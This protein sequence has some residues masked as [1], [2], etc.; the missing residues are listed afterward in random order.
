M[1]GSHGGEE[2]KLYTDPLYVGAGL[3][4]KGPCQSTLMADASPPSRA[5][6]LPHLV[7]CRVRDWGAP[8]MICGSGLER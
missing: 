5:S 2:Q 1:P 6:P 7:F 4:A 3:L 8:P